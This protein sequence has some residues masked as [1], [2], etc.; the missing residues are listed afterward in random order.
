M[1]GDQDDALST[2][3]RVSSITDLRRHSSTD[4]RVS[5]IQKLQSDAL[6]R[7][8]E[9]DQK[10][11][12]ASGT[13]I[14]ADP[15]HSGVLRVSFSDG[16]AVKR[17]LELRM[18]Q[19]RVAAWTESLQKLLTR[20][21][22][23]GLPAHWRWAMACMRATSSRGKTGVVLHSELRRLLRCANARLKTSTLNDALLKREQNAEMLGLSMRKL[24]EQT[25]SRTLYND[26][27]SL[28]QITMLLLDLSTS[29]PEIQDLFER[30]A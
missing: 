28:P 21:P 16:C 6:V 11:N 10:K 2:D 5:S 3:S 9:T 8:L 1:D 17:Y 7:K 12:R 4:S 15:L 29:V 25:E 14:A 24:P 13:H 26:T 23:F 22:L 27:L 30:N 18:P 20:S 19:E